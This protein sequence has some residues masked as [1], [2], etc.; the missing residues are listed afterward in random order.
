MHTILVTSTKNR[1]ALVAV[2]SVDIFRT[3]YVSIATILHLS[4]TCNFFPTY[5]YAHIFEI[6]MF[7][8]TKE[9]EHVNAFVTAE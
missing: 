3:S 8:I 1:L 4:S 9:V 6:C 5:A 2:D 7:T